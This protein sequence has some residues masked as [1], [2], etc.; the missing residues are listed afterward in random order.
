MRA[1]NPRF[2]GKQAIASPNNLIKIQI[3]GVGR[4]GRNR[5]VSLRIFVQNVENPPLGRLL[6]RYG[7]IYEV[8]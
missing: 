4:H 3:G 5:P 7:S 1:R 2:D 6:D 8:K